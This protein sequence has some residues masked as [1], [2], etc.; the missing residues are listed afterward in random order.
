[1][2]FTVANTPIELLGNGEVYNNILKELS[3][4]PETAKDP[5]VKFAVN[6]KDSFDVPDTLTIASDILYNPRYFA[7]KSTYVRFE[8]KGIIFEGEPLEVNIFPVMK[9][10]IL[11]IQHKFT[12][13]NFFTVEESLAKNF[14]YNIF[15]F[16]MELKFL[17]SGT[18]GSSFIHASSIEKDGKAVLFVAAGGVGKTSIMLQILKKAGW[19]YLS[20]DLSIIDSDGRV[21]FN[22]KYIQIYPYNVNNDPELYNLLMNGRG[23]IDK[24]NWYYR[25]YR[26]GESSVRRRVDPRIF[27]GR[28]KV[29]NSASIN[30]VINM[31]RTGVKDFEMDEINPHAVSNI[32]SEI[33]SF[34]INPFFKY[35]CLCNG[36]GTDSPFPKIEEVKERARQRFQEILKNI[37]CYQLRVPL[38]ATPS[39]L[40]EYIDKNTPIFYV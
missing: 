7:L 10:Q 23:I 14:M 29:S 37:P 4:Y 8:V 12:D 36:G 33:L 27:F 13:W 30:K 34:E 22:P 39:D 17:A 32:A 31:V 1:M 35:S 9:R 40:Y 21:Y 3:G 24:L 11:K 15:D 16:I 2:K 25:K 20:D 26:Y 18:Q 5:Q 6:T 38:K 19:R 28:E